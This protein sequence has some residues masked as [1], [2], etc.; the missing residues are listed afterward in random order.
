MSTRRTLAARATVALIGAGCGSNAPSGT[1]TGGHEQVTDRDKGVEFAAC[2]RDSVSGKRTTPMAAVSAS[3][4][5][6]STRTAV[7]M[8]SALI[9]GTCSRV[10]SCWRRGRGTS[11]RS[12]NRRS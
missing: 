6:L 4:D 5:P 11:P 9:A 2:M 8:S 1:S 12:P 10:G 3:A 7:T